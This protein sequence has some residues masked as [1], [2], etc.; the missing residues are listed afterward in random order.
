MI[1]E[2]L[3]A[4]YVYSAVN[5]MPADWCFDCV[6]STHTKKVLKKF[7]P[8]KK[9]TKQLERNNQRNCQAYQMDTWH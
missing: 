6:S 4:I 3:N 7:W 1:R 5:L 8:L 9:L 2:I